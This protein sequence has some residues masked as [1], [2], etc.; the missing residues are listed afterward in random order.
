MVDKP[1]RKRAK[2]SSTEMSELQDFFSNSLLRQLRAISDWTIRRS[3]DAVRARG[4]HGLRLVHETV[5]MPIELSG[6][7]LV[8][9]ARR[10]GVSKNA[11]GQLANE[12]ETLGYVRRDADPEDGRAKRLRFTDQ[13]IGMMLDVIQSEKGVEQE[14]VKLIGDEKALQLK[15]LIVE[16]AQAIKTS[17]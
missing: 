4:H 13:G 8:D 12:L 16:L 2:P 11:I 1:P 5:V 9:I 6:A 3:Y 17:L 10:R 7:R 14:I 15:T